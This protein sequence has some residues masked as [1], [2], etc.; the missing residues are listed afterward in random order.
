MKNRSLYILVIIMATLNAMSQNNIGTVIGTTTYDLQTNASS[1]NRIVVLPNGKVS[2]AWTGSTSFE[3]EFPDRGTFY[4]HFD[5]S[6][7]LGNPT[8]RIEDIRTGWPSLMISGN[9]EIFISHDPTNQTADTLVVYKRSPIGSG[10]WNKVATNVT[11]NGM[12]PRAANN[13]DTIHL[14]NSNYCGVVGSGSNQTPI[15]N[16]YTQYWRSFDAGSTWNIQG[17][18]LPGIDTA[19]GYELMNG[20]IYSID[21]KDNTVAIVV[22]DHENHLAVWKSV[23][24]GNSFTKTNLITWPDAINYDTFFVSDGAVEVIIDDANRVHVWS[25]ARKGTCVEVQI[26][27]TGR[28]AFSPLFDNGL[29]YW[30]ESFGADSFNIIAK[31]LDIDRSGDLNGIGQWPNSSQSQQ[32]TDYGQT[33]L[34][35]M[36]TVT[37]DPSNQNLYVIYMSQ[38]E[39]TDENENPSSLGAQSYTDLFGIVSKDGGST[40]SFPKNLTNSAD[41]GYESAFPVSYKEIV[42]DKI[43]ITWQRDEVAGIKV[44]FSQSNNHPIV[45]N[46][47]IYHAFDISDF[48]SDISFEASDSVACPNDTIA[49]S[50]TL[51]PVSSV[52]WAFEGATP[53]TSTEIS[54]KVVYSSPGSFSVT[55]IVN[56]IDTIA[57][58]S[59]ITIDSCNK[60]PVPNFT[61]NFDS[62]CEGNCVQFTDLTTEHPDSWLWTF[63]GGSPASSTDQYPTNICYAVPGSYSVKLKVANDN[64]ADSVIINDLIYIENCNDDRISFFPENKKLLIENFTGVQTVYGPCGEQRIETYKAQN[65]NK[66]FTMNIQTSSSYGVPHGAEE[67]LR[68]PYASEFETEFQIPGY[69]SAALNRKTV[70]SKKTIVSTGNNWQDDA[71][72]I[73]DEIASVNIEV[74][75]AFDSI[76]REVTIATQTYYTSDVADPV[77]LNLALVESNLEVAQIRFEGFTLCSG[78]TSIVDYYYLHQYVFRDLITGQWGELITEPTSEGSLNSYEHT[79]TLSNGSDPS[80]YHIIGFVSKY[81]DEILNADMESAIA[82]NITCSPTTLIEICMITVDAATN[83]NLIVWERNEDLS[84]QSYIIYKESNVSGVYDSIGIVPATELTEFIDTTS[85]ALQNSSIYKISCIDTCGNK[86]SLSEYHKTIHLTINAGQNSSWNLIWNDYEGFDVSSYNIWR[87]TDTSSIELLTSVSGSQN[88]YTDLS[89]PSGNIYY[90]IEVIHPN[91]GCESSLK[92]TGLYSSSKSNIA[93]NNVNASINPKKQ[94]LQIFPNPVKSLLTIKG[95]PMSSEEMEISIK[96]ILGRE[97]L[98]MDKKTKGNQASLDVKHLPSGVYVIAINYGEERETLRFSK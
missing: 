5:G 42:H 76:T 36:P 28:F 60:K 61:V 27:D 94:L 29:L 4:N 86:Y 41:S 23:D 91:G 58:D 8:G 9:N 95:L 84:I 82:N 26:E 80:N 1:P 18:V 51:G 39:F 64:G 89:A 10:T 35:T 87:G 43:H 40:W 30:N 77:Y 20:D 19:S 97:I 66:V 12:W 98:Y 15:C 14:I 92:T 72:D 50:L 38:V 22:G 55:A 16:G 93:T 45:V 6:S 63:E 90:Q 79:V 44:S 52:S 59:F 46:D 71:D 78:A 25:G 65:S 24:N 31:V 34:L 83:H 54:P 21:V 3:P 96:D 81:K 11:L 74:N 67:D 13:G 69:P 85:N 32:T 88:S 2:V 17:M 7:W 48:Q 33:G 37:I 73:L 68:T 56:S 75:S 47:V 57:I 62:I 70:N 49:F 53:A